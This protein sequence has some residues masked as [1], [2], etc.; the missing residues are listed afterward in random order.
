MSNYRDPNDPLYGNPGYGFFPEDTEVVD[1]FAPPREDFLTGG[2]PSY[3][4]EP[5]D[6]RNDRGIQPSPGRP[7][8]RS[9][10]ESEQK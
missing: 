5:S 8:L 3:M 10:V 7:V 1:V 6:L 2:T 4:L 9:N